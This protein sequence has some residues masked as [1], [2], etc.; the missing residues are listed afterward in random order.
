MGG[1]RGS[2]DQLHSVVIPQSLVQDPGSE[3]EYGREKKRV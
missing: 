3:R 2:A 1:G